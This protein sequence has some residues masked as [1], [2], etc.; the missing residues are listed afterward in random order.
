MPNQPEGPPATNDEIARFRAIADPIRLEIVEAL[1]LRGALTG[2]ELRRLASTRS[3][4]HHLRVLRDAGFIENVAGDEEM[5]QLTSTP[6][7]VL[8]WDEAAAQ[9]PRVELLVR[10]LERISTDRR[11]RR[12]A[13][14]DREVEE[15][16]WPAEWA[17]AAIGRDYLLSMSLSDLSELDEK[18][19]VLVEE[20]K[21][22]CDPKKVSGDAARR[23]VFVTLA[24]FPIRL[25]A[26]G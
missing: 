21:E 23:D 9:D 11:S 25:G 16:K 17:A 24:A 14:F 22:R 6:G 4:I 20:F 26:D 7:P 12:L 1:E 5:W 8:A 18:W 10:E 13:R 2:K 15:G 19:R 3:I